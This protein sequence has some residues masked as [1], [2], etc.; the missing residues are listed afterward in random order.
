MALDRVSSAVPGL[1]GRCWSE[2]H[3]QGVDRLRVLR[4]S[5]RRS[6]GTAAR[7]GF[8]V[9]SLSNLNSFS[10]PF[11]LASAKAARIPAMYASVAAW[12]S[13]LTVSNDSAVRG[14]GITGLV[15]GQSTGSWQNHD[16]EGRQQGAHGAHQCAP[17]ELG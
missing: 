11:F 3:L 17:F 15:L 16:R 9:R 10:L 12:Y 6:P 2:G 4:G 7:S 13:F 14:A 1:W 8:E 5:V